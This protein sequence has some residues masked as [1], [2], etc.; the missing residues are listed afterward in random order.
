MMIF[1]YFI[2]HK[3][4]ILVV[5]TKNKSLVLFAINN[6]LYI[7]FWDKHDYFMAKQI[8]RHK[9]TENTINNYFNNPDISLFQEFNSFTNA[10]SL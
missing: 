3:T 4:D 6:K 10:N 8:N 2:C 9:I 1:E 7:L 5:N